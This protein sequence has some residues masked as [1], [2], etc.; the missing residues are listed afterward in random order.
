MFNGI[1]LPALYSIRTDGSLVLRRRFDFA[2]YLNRT[3]APSDA[4]V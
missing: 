3:G 1:N 2:D 4:V